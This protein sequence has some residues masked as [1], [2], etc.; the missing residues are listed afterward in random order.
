MAEKCKKL[1]GSKLGF[2]LVIE[3]DD[4][5]N[6]QKKVIANYKKNLQIKGFRKGSAP[7]DMVLASIGDQKL[8]F[9]GFNFALDE[10]YRNFVITN[11]LRPVSA[12][13]VDFSGMDKIPV[14]VKMEVEVFPEI[15]LGNYQK[16][17]IEQPKIVITEAEVSQLIETFLSQSGKGSVVERAAKKGD[18]LDVDFSGKDEKGNVLPNTDGKNVKFAIG[19]GQ[20]LPDLEKA[21]IGM[22]AGEEKKDV[23]VSFPKDYPAPEMAG[24]KVPFDIKLN[25]VSEI[26][27]DKLDEKTIEEIVGRKKSVEE[28]R[29][30]VKA[31][32]EN[33]KMSAEKQKKITVYEDKLVKIVKIDLPV[34]WIENEVEMRMKKITE[35]PQ[36][37]H[38]PEQFW[39]QVGKDEAALKKEFTK[40][41]ERNLK[42]FLAHAE[43]IKKENVKLD[44]AEKE[45][46]HQIVHTRGFP[47]DNHDMELEK[48]ETELKIDKYLNG[49]MI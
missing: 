48:V 29:K 23:K 12:P 10:K 7:D 19:S 34:S 42:V 8:M 25:T 44:K 47:E 27:A 4:L 2:S 39:K 16:L 21:Y 15:V 32:I 46:A 31:S 18:L 41:S 36:Y 20:F 49:L 37:K 40:D 22:K 13:K 17:K 33:Q 26:S 9:E 6:A 38:D 43:I 14:E 1:S 35:S 11:E 5:E 28:F 30:D 3:K 24:K 45:K